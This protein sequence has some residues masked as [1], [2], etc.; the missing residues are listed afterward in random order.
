M[1]SF[2]AYVP[3]Y[4]L[5]LFHDGDSEVPCFDLWVYKLVPREFPEPGME[6]EWIEIG[7]CP[8]SIP[9]QADDSTKNEFLNKAAGVF[10]KAL[11]EGLK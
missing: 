3:G 7:I 1:S 5:E 11:P 2:W 9:Y 4:G 6:C 8:T 10:Y